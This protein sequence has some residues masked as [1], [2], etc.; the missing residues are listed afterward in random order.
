M[1]KYLKT[2]TIE[3]VIG[4]L[5]LGYNRVSV[6][7]LRFMRLYVD[8]KLRGSINKKS[9]IYEK[10]YK[11]YR[12]RYKKWWRDRRRVYRA[13]EGVIGGNKGGEGN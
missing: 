10:N 1:V 13:R 9:L 7:V 2:K 8:I 6:G 3:R 5:G 4:Q 11:V 12:S